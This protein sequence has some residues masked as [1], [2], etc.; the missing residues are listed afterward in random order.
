MTQAQTTLPGLRCWD[1]ATLKAEWEAGRV[2]LV[3]V[4]EPAE[5][6]GERIPGA[7]CHPLSKLNPA[8]IKCPEDKVLVLYCQSGNRSYRA[9]QQLLAAGCEQVTHLQGGILAWKD[10]GY[11]VERNPKAPISLFR[12]VQIVA[13]SLV[14]LGT[15]LGATVSPWFLLLSG[16]V[17]AGLV[18]AGV[19]NTCALGMLLAKLPYNQRVGQTWQS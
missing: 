6:A 18:F 4:R 8:E 10:A 17:G 15:I 1:P 11:P 19:T 14:L 7:V 12:Q 16:F 13:G 3:D 9:A 2:W 5:Y